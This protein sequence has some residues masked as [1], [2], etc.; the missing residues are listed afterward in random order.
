MNTHRLQ[1]AQK[2][3]LGNSIGD[4]FGESFFGPEGAVY[5]A[6]HFREIPQTNWEF[7]DDT[8]MAIAIYT[9]L[10]MFGEINQDFIA[11]AFARNYHLDFN[12]GYGPAMHRTMRAIEA[13]ENWKEVSKA[14]FSG[15]GSMGNG[16][17]MRAGLI[18]A[19]F[20]DDLKKMKKQA[21]LSSEITHANEEGCVGAMAVAI[22][23]AI[24][25][26]LLIE[27]KTLE[28]NEFIKKIVVELPNC[29]TTSKIRKSLTVFP[30]YDIRTV[31]SILGNGVKM[32]AQ[33]TVPISI[34]IAAHYQTN[35]K[36]AIWRAVSALGDRDTI[37]AIVGAIT[38]MNTK[39]ENIPV[40]WKN[41]V[42]NWRESQFYQKN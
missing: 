10:E 20:Y 32:I 36:E 28:P 14:A 3:L 42:E 5:S 31:V 29:D 17:A 6:I 19:Y 24:N 4:A 38:I 16:G 11:K 41:K 1:L 18:G 25:T 35:F 40:D 7:T 8:V 21:F 34:W 39:D 37:C 13:G 26:Q 9:S 22:A 27:N 30:N 2:S 33:D 15:M 23:T 12:R